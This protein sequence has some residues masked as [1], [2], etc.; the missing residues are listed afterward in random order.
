MKK[1]DRKP[2]SNHLEDFIYPLNGH[3]PEIMNVAKE[4]GYEFRRDA[5]RKEIR[6]EDGTLGGKFRGER[7][8]IARV[9]NDYVKVYTS[10]IKGN[11]GYRN[12]G[13]MKFA[14]LARGFWEMGGVSK[15]F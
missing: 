11:W 15:G 9:I 14:N 4:M 5:E 12:G 10:H 7:R 13:I 8:V 2:K 1:G 3:L 6:I